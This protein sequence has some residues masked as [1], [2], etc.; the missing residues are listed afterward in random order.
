VTDDYTTFVFSAG[1]DLVRELERDR[2]GLVIPNIT[3]GFM[4]SAPDLGA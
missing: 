3:D 1:R 4:G 2:R